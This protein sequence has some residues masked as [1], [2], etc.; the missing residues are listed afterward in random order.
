MF[1]VYCFDFYTSNTRN[2]FTRQIDSHPE[3]LV[4]FLTL[5]PSDTDP[6]PNTDPDPVTFIKK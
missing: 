1:I 4:C 5:T 2:T 3:P 6:Y